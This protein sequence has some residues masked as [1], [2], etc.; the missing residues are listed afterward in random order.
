MLVVPSEWYE[1]GPLTII[2]AFAT[3]LPVIASR[4][5]TMAE[6][7]SDGVTGRCFRRADAG[8]LARV[9]DWVQSHPDEVEVM[10]RRARHEFEVKYSA[11]LNYRALMQIYRAAMAGD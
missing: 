11:E 4:L 7:V 9:M 3:G 6:M 5:G 10:A 1:T 2:E 8:D